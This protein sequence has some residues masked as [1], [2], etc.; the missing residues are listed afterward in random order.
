MLVNF[1]TL[2]LVGGLLASLW[3][4]RHYSDKVLVHPAFWLAV[5]GLAGFFVAPIPV[6]AAVVLTAVALPVFP[7]KF[8]STSS[9]RRSRPG[10]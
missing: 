5:I 2:L 7:T 9:I 10:V 3:P 8:E 4:L 1:L 6:A